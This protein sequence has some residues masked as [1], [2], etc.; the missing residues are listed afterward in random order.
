MPLG[1]L[2]EA[3]VDPAAASPG[4]RTCR[5]PEGHGASLAAHLC[6]NWALVTD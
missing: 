3:E 4:L 1:V 2:Q 6:H 5:M